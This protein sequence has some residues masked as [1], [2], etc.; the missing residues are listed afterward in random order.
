MAGTATGGLSRRLAVAPAGPEDEA[1]LRA[2]LRSQPLPGWVSLGFEREPD[3]FAAAAS[4]GER[5]A[6]LLARERTE[7]GA[8]GSL[9]G[10]FERAVRRVYLGGEVRRLGYLGQ[11]RTATGWQ[12][13]Y[14]TYRLLRLGFEQ[15]QQRLRGA[16]ELPYDITSILADNRSARRILTAGLPGLPR[17][18]RLSGY[19]TLVYRSGRCRHSGARHVENGAA[20]GLPA[21]AD[22]LQR[23]Y[24]RYRFAPFWDEAALLGA[25]LTADDFLVLRRGK[26][27]TACLGLWDQRALKQTVVRGYRRPLGVLRPLVNLA[28]PLLGYPA[29]PRVGEALRQ[30]WLSHLACDGDEPAALQVLLPAALARARQ[31]GLEQ[32]LLGLADGHPLLPTARGLRRHLNYRSDIYLVHWPHAS[33]DAVNGAERGADS[34][35]LHLEL[36]TL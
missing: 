29:L 5:H 31:L 28:A 22:C 1:E 2:L 20:L 14:R 21:I 23:N 10:F 18:R 17:Y 7:T 3:Y 34:Q 27:V 12:R 33:T 35:T 32:V 15:V 9:V 36:A 30:G 19:H 4:E 26:R 24:R 8:R 25:G 6:V 16:D 13:G 11:L